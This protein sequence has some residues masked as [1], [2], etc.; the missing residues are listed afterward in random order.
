MLKEGLGEAR[1][2]RLRLETSGDGQDLV[3]LRAL[4]LQRL[5][6]GYSP[7]LNARRR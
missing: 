4:G 5:E 1:T 7:S 2:R 3:L 6:H